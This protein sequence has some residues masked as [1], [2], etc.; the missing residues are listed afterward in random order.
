VTRDDFKKQTRY[1][2][3][4]CVAGTPDEV[5]LRA[6]RYDRDGDFAY[7][8]YVADYYTGDDWRFYRTAYDENGY[9]FDT[10]QIIQKT[11]D[12]SQYGCAHEE[13]IGLMVSRDYLAAHQESGIRFKVSGKTGEN[14]FYIPPSYVKDF[15]AEVSD[16]SSSTVTNAAYTPSVSGRSVATDYEYARQQDTVEAYRDFLY[17]HRTKDTYH[18]AALKRLDELLHPGGKTHEDPSYRR[19]P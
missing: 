18:D 10:I 15:L 8:I 1:K 19:I 7:Q 2:G 17:R 3:P 4:N 9:Q 13:H 11:V 6:W 16:G 12:C 14:I 5:F